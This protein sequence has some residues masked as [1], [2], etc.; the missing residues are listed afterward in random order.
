MNTTV[1]DPFDTQSSYDVPKSAGGAYLKFEKGQTKFLPLMSPIVGWQ[2]WNVENKPVRLKNQPQERYEH[3]EGIRAEEDG[4]YKVQHFWAFPVIDCADGKVKILEITQKGIQNDMRE[5][6]KNPDWGN[7]VMKYTFTVSKTGEK[8]STEY[9]VM[10]N[11]LHALPADWKR[12]WDDV[13]A[14]GFNLNELYSGGDPFSPSTVAEAPVID[15]PVY[16]AEDTAEPA[17]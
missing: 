15:E 1:N 4:K 9:T 7:P 10:A 11:P 3:L 17:E 5:Y 13:Q 12:A 2:Y 8:L 6:V 14:K 16:V